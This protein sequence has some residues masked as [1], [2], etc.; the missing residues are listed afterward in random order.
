MNLDPHLL[1]FTKINSKWIIDLNVKWKTIKLVQD[2]TGENLGDLGYGNQLLDT[3]SKAQPVKE[4]INKPD[5]IKIKNFVLWKTLR[6]WEN[7]P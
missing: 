4:I 7:K 5:F 1:P 3:V 6:E 2:N